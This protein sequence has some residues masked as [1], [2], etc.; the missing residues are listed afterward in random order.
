MGQ[1]WESSVRW[2]EKTPSNVPYADDLFRL[3]PDAKLVH[4]LRDPRAVFASRRRLLLDRYGSY[5]KAHRLVREWNQSARQIERLRRYPGNCLVIHYEDLIRDSRNVM[6]QVCQFAG[7]NFFPGLLEPTWAGGDWHGNSAYYNALNGID[8][9]PVDR[10]KK[11]LTQDEI[12]W[13]DTHCRTGMAL[14][15]YEPTSNA[16]FSFGRWAR[17]LP[18]ESIGGY[19]RARKSSLCQM[20]GL[21]QDCRYGLTSAKPR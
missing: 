12:W 18:G 2:V 13:I 8:T 6:Q 7:I 5:T 10:W 21:L 9:Q 11:E 16:L 3:F 4:I 14:A 15:G 19:V 1:D 20:A 17:R